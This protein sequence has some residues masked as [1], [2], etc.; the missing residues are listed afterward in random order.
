[1]AMSRI[2]E[3]QPCVSKRGT[4]SFPWGVM[5]PTPDGLALAGIGGAVNV[6]ADFMKRDEWR[7]QCFPE[8][9]IAKQFQD[10]YF[11]FFQTGTS[12]ANFIFDR[13]NQQGPLVFGNFNVAGAFRDPETVKLYL[14]QGGLI[15]EWDADT[16]NISP[17]DWK[18][19]V[20]VLPKPVNYGAMQIEADFGS[21]NA[22]TQFDTQ[23]AQDT[24]INTDLLD[25]DPL[26]GLTTWA[27][28]SSYGTGT[29][30][31]SVDGIKMATC[32][33][34]GTSST[35]EPTWPQV[36]GGTATDGTV[37]WKQVWDVQGATRGAMGEYLLGYYE[38]ISATDP[39]QISTT[40]NGWGFP[41][42]ASILQGGTNTTFDTRN[43]TVQV[44][45]ATTGTDLDLVATRNITTRDVVRLPRGLK[46]DQWAIEIS[47]NVAVKYF[48]IAE[49]A[50]EL[51][52]I[53]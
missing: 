8:T 27:A 4:V 25:D 30:V 14:I 33:V 21:L 45:A 18:S 43:I 50:K 31:K 13:A 46:A 23:S 16:S 26:A 38:P 34:G 29:S 1:M 3:N 41:M 11:G 17:Y 9:I 44:Y 15:K 49:T 2:E 51:G 36:R 42:G 20:V 52:I 6:I 5:W 7:A 10:V 19:K 37:Q 35:V 24:A 47:G 39:Y 53:Q 48:K 32:I 28:T 40:Y 22:Q 12:G